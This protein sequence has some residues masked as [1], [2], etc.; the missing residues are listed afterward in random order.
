MRCV[1]DNLASLVRKSITC[2]SLG[3]ISGPNNRGLGRPFVLAGALALLR[4][5][6]ARHDGVISSGTP[7]PSTWPHD[8]ILMPGITPF[9]RRVRS[10]GGACALRCLRLRFPHRKRRRSPREVVVARI[11]RT[12]KAA[13]RKNLVRFQL[14][15]E[16]SRD[17]AA[18]AVPPPKSFEKSIMADSRHAV[19]SCAS[20]RRRCG[21]DSPPP[22][23]PAGGVRR[24]GVRSR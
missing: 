23:G 15:A 5:L 1:C 17:R 24:P 3:I 7:P 19:R 4:A 22:R 16:P 8:C 14:F 18:S 10:E 13:A 6:V 11:L 20:V 12:G 21:A 9:P 2:S